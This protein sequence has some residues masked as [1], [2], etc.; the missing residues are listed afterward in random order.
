MFSSKRQ[1]LIIVWLLLLILLNL[2]YF[3]QYRNNRTDDAYITF[4]IARNLYKHHTFSYNLGERHLVTTSP[5]SAMLLAPFAVFDLNAFPLIANFL[6][7]LYLL[8]ALLSLWFF[9][10]RGKPDF[11]VII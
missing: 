5:L 4:R 6:G 3:Y 2:A 7:N 11:S 9:L 1:G 10:L 8:I